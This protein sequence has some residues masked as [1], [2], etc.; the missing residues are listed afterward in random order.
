MIFKSENYKQTQK[1]KHAMM[2]IDYVFSGLHDQKTYLN[3]TEVWS[4][5]NVYSV[6]CWFKPNL[7]VFFGD[8]ILSADS[9]G[10]I[11]IKNR[12]ESRTVD[13]S[14]IRRSP[15]DMVNIPVIY[16]ATFH[17]RWCRISEPSTVWIQFKSSRNLKGATV[18]L[19]LYIWEL[20]LAPQIL[21]NVP[22]YT[23][24]NHQTAICCEWMRSLK[25]ASVY[26]ILQYSNS[27]EL[28]TATCKY[29]FLVILD[30]HLNP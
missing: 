19:K 15:V 28:T 26:M 10:S 17:L 14:E 16:K 21:F 4:I 6:F 3:I 13:G 7:K 25:G 1:T 5:R 23:Q 2:M 30:F 8:G 12:S 22:L 18:P 27:S 29:V 11:E 9:L 24:T 20:F